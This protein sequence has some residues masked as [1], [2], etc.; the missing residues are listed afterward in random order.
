MLVTFTTSPVCGECMN[1]ESP[2]YNPTWFIEPPEPK[3]TKSP[4]FNS[5]L[6]TFFPTVACDLDTLG[7]LTPAPFL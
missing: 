6:D 1:L 2:T 3:K 7:K 4:G 5:A